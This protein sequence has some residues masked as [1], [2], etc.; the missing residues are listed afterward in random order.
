MIG[1]WLPVAVALVVVLSSV[2]GLTALY[3]P[4]PAAAQQAPLT[5]DVDVGLTVNGQTATETPYFWGVDID[6]VGDPN[7][8]TIMQELN[9]T[10]ITSLRY[11][12]AWAD[13]SNWTNG[14][15][16]SDSGTCGPLV[17][18][19]Y[20]FAALCQAL[21]GDRC[22]IG[23]PA[24]INDS[25]A[26]VAMAVHLSAFEGGW[27]P[28]CWTVGNEPVGWKHFNI[29]WTSWTTSDS[30]SPTDVQYA[31][32][33][34]N[35]IG[36]V[37]HALPG[38]CV[39]GLV[40]GKSNAVGTWDAAEIS[41][42]PN[43]SATS[44][45]VYPSTTCATQTLAQFMSLSS[46]TM[47][48][49]QYSWAVANSSGVPAYVSEFA[50]AETGGS[51]CAYMPGEGDAAFTS[52]AIAQALELGIPQVD[53]YRFSGPT[54]DYNMVDQ[55]GTETPLYHLYAGLFTHM[56]LAQVYN[57]TMTGANSQTFAV[58]GTSGAE[59]SSLLISN[60]APTSYENV[61]L[62]GIAAA[63]WTGTVYEQGTNGAVTTAAYSPTGTLEL[64]PMSSAVIQVS[65]SGVARPPPAPTDVM[66]TAVNQT[67]ANLT[68]TQSTGTDLVN[69]TVYLYGTSGCGGTPTGYG[70]DG[71]MPGFQVTGLSPGSAYGAEVTVWNGS[72]QSSSPSACVGFATSAAPPPPPPPNS[73]QP[74]GTLLGTP[75]NPNVGTILLLVLVTAVA[76]IVVWVGVHRGG[77]R[78]G[79]WHG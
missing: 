49:R 1:R 39:V 11:G 73:T 76:A 7:T 3:V 71:I 72:G 64:G 34:H 17:N 33:S 43:V 28:Y 30:S 5:T 41:E 47:M 78:H 32:M 66:V 26:A 52:A 55:N 68:W 22:Y 67:S 60:A 13:E 48:A 42:S 75:G 59:H 70:T 58:L 9:A 37:R 31:L 21:P 46:L 36:A 45:H 79:P 44:F 77:R 24:E 51:G 20:D 54:S 56:D 19:P 25:A 63:G 23:L 12:A 18:M 69:N 38:A 35:Y 8:A 61:S 27:T 40:F 4:P 53:V 50:P 16:Y 15:L 65:G 14:C 10:P 2:A 29:P 6:G 62:A 57:V 74:N